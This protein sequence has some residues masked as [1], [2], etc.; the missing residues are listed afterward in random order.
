[1]D[2]A[3]THWLSMGG[4]ALVGALL[5]TW[6]WPVDTPVAPRAVADPHAWDGPIGPGLMSNTDPAPGPG[7]GAEP[8][9]P[10][11][12]PALDGNGHLLQNMALRALFDAFLLRGE[13]P[14]LRQRAAQ[15][16]AYLKRSLAGAPGAEALALA[17]RYLAYLEAHDALLQ[18][19]NI[20][21]S[22]GAPITPQAL[23]Q[24]D[25]WQQQRARL[26][27]SMLGIALA[28]LW[29]SDDDAQLSAAV[30]DVRVRAQPPDP[31]APEPDSAT[32]RARR[33]NNASQ[34]AAHEATLDDVFGRATQSVAAA[35]AG[36]RLWQAHAAKFR[37]ALAQL[38]APDQQ[39]AGERARQIDAL[40]A[41]IFTDPAE[42]ERSWTLAND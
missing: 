4:A 5:V 28:Q 10:S 40:R 23:E 19:Q 17:A 42:R 22:P 30:A 37:T 14:E 9:E 21:I 26:R 36:E 33:L 15:L 11:T 29:F 18:R 3:R 12:P 39:D 41:A 35:A 6:Y 16:D 38:R 20:V 25:G 13:A 2:S 34:D 32:L 1:M 27:Q 8:G 24:M 31:G 7:L